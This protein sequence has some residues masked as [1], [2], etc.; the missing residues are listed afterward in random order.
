[1]PRP[2]PTVLDLWRHEWVRMAG[3]MAGESLHG[4]IILILG[5]G[6]M[7]SSASEVKKKAGAFSGLL[8]YLGNLL[9]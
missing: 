5:K 1:M 7:P 6:L 8:W 4:P 2:Q 3:R 9:W